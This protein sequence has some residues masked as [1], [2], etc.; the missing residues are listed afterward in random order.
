[1]D[2]AVES[3]KRFG[4]NMEICRDLA[5]LSPQYFKQIKES[6]VP[7]NALKVLSEKLLPFNSKATPERLVE[8]LR[9]FASSWDDF[10]LTIIGDFCN[11]TF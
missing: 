3:I 7:T 11:F 5:V 10:K 8:E 6:G 2:T 9:S 1:M 4:K